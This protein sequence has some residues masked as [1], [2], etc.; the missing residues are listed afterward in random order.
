MQQLSRFVSPGSL[1]ILKILYPE[2]DQKIRTRLITDK[3]NG[4]ANYSKL[5][6]KPGSFI[7]EIKNVFWV[8]EYQQKEEAKKDKK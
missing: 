4:E 1:S 6:P 3:K 5:T 2:E 7:G 8:R